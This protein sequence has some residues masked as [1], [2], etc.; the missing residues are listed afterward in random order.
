MDITR[1]STLKS[2]WLY[3]LQLK[4]EK[5][6]TISK[7]KT[8]NWLWLRSWNPY[9]KIQW[10]NK[11]IRIPVNELIDTLWCI[12]ASLIGNL[13]KNPPAMQETL[14]WSL[15][16]DDPRR[17][18]RPPAPVFLGFHCG[19]ADEESACNAGDLGLEDPWRREWLPLQYPGLE[20]H[21]DGVVHGVAKNWT[22]L[23]NFHFH[24]WCI[25]NVSF[26]IWFLI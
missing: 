7:N 15:G 16:Q 17:R 3:S 21:M 9:G 10:R 2:D 24:F 22:W 19:S 12:M 18:D 13:V 1:Q 6:Y 4:M 5:L 11:K 20:N 26:E 14:A 23:S 25:H 8:R